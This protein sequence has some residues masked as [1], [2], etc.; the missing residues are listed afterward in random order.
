MTLE[1]L[2]E[3]MGYAEGCSGGVNSETCGSKA[4]NFQAD[5]VDSVLSGY[6]SHPE[7]YEDSDTVAVVKLKDGRFGTFHEWSD[8]SGH[9]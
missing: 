5:D 1:E 2:K 6:H 8:T 3:C 9:G 7:G 4:W